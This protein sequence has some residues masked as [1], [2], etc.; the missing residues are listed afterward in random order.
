MR[1]K[2]FLFPLFALLTFSATAQREETLLGHRGFRFSGI[3]GGSNHQI[4]RFGST[5][6]Y[7]NGGHFGLEFGKSLLVG[8]SAYNL[9]ETIQWDQLAN[10]P[11]K[12]RFQ[13]LNLG[14][15]ISSYKSIHP[16]VNVDLAP[17][18]IEITQN[19]ETQRDNIFVVQPAVGLE[20]NVLRWFRIGLQG[21]YRYVTDTNLGTL[22]DKDLSGAFGQASL[23]F[24]WSWGRSRRS[25]SNGNN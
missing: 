18:R 10:Q 12:M 22:S 9:E 4:T 5:N 2:L 11:F 8:M 13:G 1:T 3:W 16:T 19:G 23:K 7:V 17:G 6:S 21:G 20:I 14:Y 15:G 24:G 25:S